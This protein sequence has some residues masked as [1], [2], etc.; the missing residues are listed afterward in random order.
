MVKAF[1][2][3][4]ECLNLVKLPSGGVSHDPWSW[5]PLV[6]DLAAAVAIA[7]P[8]SFRNLLELAKGLRPGG[9]A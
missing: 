5:A 2:W 8:V 3:F 7:A 1:A 9:R 6:L 4:P